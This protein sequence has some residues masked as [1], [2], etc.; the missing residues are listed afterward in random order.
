MQSRMVALSLGIALAAGL[1]Y[2]LSPYLLLIAGVALLLLCLRLRHQS[3][4]PYLILLLLL[5]LGLAYGNHYGQRLLAQRLAPNLEDQTLALSGVV[6]GLPK[7]SMKYGQNLQRFE[8]Q[9]Q[10]S[11]TAVG[12]ELALQKVQLYWYNGPTLIPGQHWQLSVSLRPPRGLSN[13]AGFDY[14]AWLLQQGI[15]GQ[16]KVVTS[17]HN[18]LLGQRYNS[19]DYWRWRAAKFLDL[20]LQGLSH[21][22]LIKALL[23]ADKRGV[24]SEQWQLLSTTGTIHLWVISGLHIGILA[25]LGFYLGRLLALLLQPQHVIAYACVT[26]CIFAGAY[27]AAAGFSLPTQRAVIM[28]WVFMLSLLFCRH[29]SLWYRYNLALLLCLLLD[30][31]AVISPSFYLSFMA[32]AAILLCC[33][34]RYTAQPG[35][36][37]F[38]QQPWLRAQWAVFVGLTPVLLLLFQQAPLVAVL[39]NVIAIPVFSLLLVPGLMLAALLSL[40]DQGLI[41]QALW[42]A[43]NTM[44]AQFMAALELLVAHA[45]VLYGG[46]HNWLG[47]LLLLSASL[48]LLLPR[49]IPGR[50]LA[51]LLCIP[52]WYYP[53]PTKTAHQLQALVF[54]VGQGLAVLLSSNDKHVLFDTGAAWQ[55]G[56]MANSVILPYLR[57][58]GID[59]LD[60]LVV[61]HGDNDHAG[62]A[63]Q[64]LQQL[65]VKQ[66]YWGEQQPNYYGAQHCQQQRWQWYGVD[67]QFLAA[68]KSKNSSGN[69]ASCVLKVS[70]AYHTILLTGDIERAREQQLV[71]DYQQ[72]LQADI[73]LAPHHGSVSSSSWPFIKR[74]QPRVVIYSTGY[75]NRFNHPNNKVVQ[76]YQQLNARSF[77]T[78]EQG[79]LILDATAT[80]FTIQSQRANK[81]YYWQ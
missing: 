47:A 39:V 32:V 53:S 9:L 8:L 74:V 19:I 78:A 73:L 42:L 18:Q 67:F 11:Q 15:D 48:L 51:C 13:P 70:N 43:A 27:A 6:V 55:G 69:N 64:L 41:S 50:W 59:S 31:L 46:V 71:A 25:V 36:L 38:W 35:Q 79:A 22:S 62:G 33:S 77:N 4:Q 37:K 23:L 44:L 20:Q 72:Q 58:Q 34:L 56:S 1:P 66:V 12:V 63:A 3:Y 49:A 80:E 7:H 30:P 29:L 17:A 76:R 24:S 5:L 16:G 10:N 45:P 40:L 75:K 14:Q 57:S 60:V 21:A 81:A 61:S 28:V 52:L 54:D 26:A 65:E 2:L 68:D